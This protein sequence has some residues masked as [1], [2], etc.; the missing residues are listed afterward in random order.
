MKTADV[1]VY[2]TKSVPRIMEEATA[3]IECARN[4]CKRVRQMIENNESAEPALDEI[5]GCCDDLDSSLKEI[6]ETLEQLKEA[7]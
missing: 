5:E 1:Q 4:D 7:I 6:K 3:T 2:I